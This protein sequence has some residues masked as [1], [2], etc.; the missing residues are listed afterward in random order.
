LG[1]IVAIITELRLPRLAVP[2][3]ARVAEGAQVSILTVTWPELVQT[4]PVLTAVLGAWVVV[5]T[6]GVFWLVGAPGVVADVDRA[7]SIIAARR[8]IRGPNAP[9]AHFTAIDGASDLIRTEAVIRHINA[10]LN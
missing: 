6:Q 1:A 4:P 7:W 3:G 2:K 10:A 8:V 5:I 9:L